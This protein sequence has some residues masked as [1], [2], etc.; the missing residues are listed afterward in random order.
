[1]LTSP[2]TLCTALATPPYSTSSI[3]DVRVNLRKS[4]IAIEVENPNNI[5]DI[6]SATTLGPWNVGCSRPKQAKYLYGVVSPVEIDADI[7]SLQACLKVEGSAE[8]G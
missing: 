2:A 7:E 4:L 6:L 3:K 5:E 8:L 1:M